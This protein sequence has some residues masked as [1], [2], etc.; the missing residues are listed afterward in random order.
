MID[1]DMADLIL[2][3]YE[4]KNQNNTRYEIWK[5]CHYKESGKSYQMTNNYRTIKKQTFK[6]S[7]RV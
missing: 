7:F 4:R 6:S 3:T 1:Y 2:F 5:T